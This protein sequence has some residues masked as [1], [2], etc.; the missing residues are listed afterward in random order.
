[1]QKGKTA[2]IFSALIL[3]LALSTTAT[4][5]QVSR[6]A[7]SLDPAVAPEAPTEI[8]M[9][10]SPEATYPGTLRIYIVERF[11][12]YSNVIGVPF[13]NGFLDFATVEDFTV[14]DGATWESN[15]TYDASSLGGIPINR[16]RAYAVVLNQ[17]AFVGDADPPS[18][19]AFTGNRVDAAATAWIGNPGLNETGAGYTHTVLV[20]EGMSTW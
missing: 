12:R 10:K 4:E 16:L 20:E 8:V 6:L 18:G 14:D 9:V 3:A 13:D 15:I 11:S 2:F 1:M 17:N 5:P 19:R 7:E